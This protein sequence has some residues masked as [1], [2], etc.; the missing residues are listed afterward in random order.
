MTYGLK[1][2]AL[3]TLSL[4]LVVVA[5]KFLEALGTSG[6][7]IVA[8]ILIAY[9]ILPLVEALRRRMPLGAA[10]AV[11][12]LLIL[13]LV[14]AFSLVVVPPLVTQLHGLIVQ[15]PGLAQSAQRDLS[16]PNN[17]FVKR[18]PPDVQAYLN[19][20]P[21]QV[22]ALVAK[23]G[24]G[25]AQRALG[26][27]FSAA[28][29]FL[30][31]IIVPI[32]TAYLLT[33]SEELKRACLGF[34]PAA[35]RPKALSILRDLNVVLG[36]FV[37]GQLLDGAILAALVTIMLAIMHVPYALVIGLGAGVLNLVPYLGAVIGFIPSVA[38]ALLYNGWQNALIVGI[39]F[40]VIQQVDGNV[41]L[42]RVMKQNL[43]L[44]P[45]VI[46]LSILIFSA[47]FG[48]VGTFLAVPVT[49]MLRV[50]KMHFFPAPAEPDAVFAEA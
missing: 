43:Q 28:A 23:Y 38:L 34:V 33:D 8:A 4:V 12:Y 18:M 37:R 20:L 13:A 42:P 5:V 6:I 30:S 21:A 39:L 41:I 47:L 7:L 36:A 31:V 50:L 44:S 29:L 32:L 19:T 15:L 16:D 22:N 49:A 1:V 35:A 25:V 48:L 45:L 14:A 27:A 46:I 40:A 26:A 11:S 9:L 10:L 2:V 17:S 24:F 3:I